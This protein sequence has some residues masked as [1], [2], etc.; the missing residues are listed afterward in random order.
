MMELRFE[1]G[2]PSKKWVISL[3]ARGFKVDG[4]IKVSLARAENAVVSAQY[5]PAYRT[6]KAVGWKVI[7]KF[8]QIVDGKAVLNVSK[9][10]RPLL[11]SLS[12]EFE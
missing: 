10:K 9:G 1:N 11:G 7:L 8:A 6:F 5:V 12:V 3:P 4:P 2:V